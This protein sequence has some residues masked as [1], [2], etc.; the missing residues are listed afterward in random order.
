M[1]SSQ[2]LLFAQE[3][4]AAALVGS[5]PENAIYSDWAATG[6]QA[7]QS[8]YRFPSTNGT[9]FRPDGARIIRIPIKATQHLAPQEST[10][11]F[12][13]VN[14]TN[15]EPIQL[16]QSAHSFFSR[17][18]LRGPHD[19][20][21]DDIDDYHV[22]MAMLGHHQIGKEHR[23]T[24][25]AMLSGYAQ[26]EILSSMPNMGLA[27]PYVPNAD[28]DINSAQLSVM[29]HTTTTENTPFI[30][31]GG[32]Q[33][34]AIPLPGLL[35][36]SKYLPLHK[37]AGLTIELHLSNRNEAVTS[38]QDVVP[39]AYRIA[40]VQYLATLIS[41]GQTYENLLDTMLLGGMTLSSP[42]WHSYRR[43]VQGGDY[44]IDVPERSRSLKSLFVVQRLTNDVNDPSQAVDRTPSHSWA[45]NDE[46]QL[47]IGGMS[48]PQAPVKVTSLAANK[49]YG[50]SEAYYELMKA[51]GLSAHEYRAGSASLSADYL[52]DQFYNREPA[53]LPA[54]VAAY[55]ANPLIYTLNP[56][57]IPTFCM[58][59]DTESFSRSS[60]T[61]GIDNKDNHLNIS[62]STKR[63]IPTFVGSEA[64]PLTVNVFTLVDQSVILMSGALGGFLEVAN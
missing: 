64:V 26:E 32:V 63:N 50:T 13:I 58:G 29:S 30:A 60:V 5:R 20:I 3:S 2:D 23:S 11:F 34:F 54:N 49:A 9:E 62:F 35:S 42:T 39:I 57:K 14:E 21:I 12:D 53:R 55:L 33:R 19:E 16:Q 36:T 25:G 22:L 45:G 52:T 28:V 59:I 61:S 15:A 40:N 56:R 4:A 43:T 24:V 8:V 51:F 10:L 18:I 6:V 37:M 47:Q 38:L 31:F 46:Y 17:Y 7:E 44:T 1:A 41:F 27:I 48:V